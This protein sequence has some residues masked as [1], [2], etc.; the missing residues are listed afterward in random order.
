[1]KKTD[2]LLECLVIYTRL[3]NRPFSADALV[4]DLPVEEGR[5]TPRLFSHESQK[6][7]SAFS[8]AALRGGF[9]SKLVQ[10]KLADI[11]SLLLPV[12]L[13][14]RDDN[15]CILIELSENKKYAKVILPDYEDG[16]ANWIKYED[17][18][19]EYIGYAFL[20]KPI[21]NHENVQKRVL[22][23]EKKHWFWGT[24]KY[25]RTIYSDVLV[26]SF[27]INLFALASPLFTMNVY[28]RVVPN[29]AIDTM[30]VLATGVFVV[31]TFDMLLKFM[32][33][34]F[35]ENAAKKSDIIMSSII[36]EKVLNLK[37]SEK[38]K[39]VGSFASNLKDFDSIRGFFAST[40][41][42][43]MVDLPFTLVFLFVIYIIADWLVYLPIASA[44][45]IVLYSFILERPLRRSVEST[46]E[47]SAYKNSILIETLTAL[48][49]IKSMG[50]TGSFQW[51]WEEATGDIA[52]KSLKSRI[53]TNSITTF[54]NYMVSINTV[55]LVVAGV[56]SINDKSLSMGGLIAVVMMGSRAL[57]PL[58]QVASLVANFQQ[59]K[60]AYN[61]IDDIMNLPTER[62]V[63][64][65]FV[66][67]PLFKGKI[68]FKNVSFVYP[69]TENAVLNNVSFVIEPGESVGIIGTNG[70]GKSTIEKLI[71]GL[72]SPTEGSILIDDIDISQIDPADLR[73]NI[74]YIPQDVVLFQ[75]T[76][77]QNIVSKKPDATDEQ[78]LKAAEISG[79]GNFINTNPL[80]FD[81]NV[82]ERGEFLSG[83]Q[84]QAIGVARA[85]IEVSPILLF[86]EPSNA[87]DSVNENTL[88]HT[89]ENL[90]KNNTL[91]L[92]SH[93]NT[94]LS[95]VDRLI[96]IDNG[97]KALDGTKES[98]IKQLNTPKVKGV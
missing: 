88:I 71:I 93:K 36:Y 15:A 35:L 16:S 33:S 91:I 54:V 48:E 29:N 62:E 68:E 78:I 30:W 98:V 4:A 2:P 65:K 95:L 46:Y 56:Y 64:K 76:L 70:S 60:T 89:M 39:S 75:G 43:A 10:Y 59:T 92:I 34:Y 32:R 67:R 73:R 44:L 49:T 31:Y 79:V 58:G 55:A 77:K 61:A 53:I 45:I 28:D 42:A 3:H 5:T 90:K 37:M 47:A 97:A 14:L 12:I 74:S 7:K 83:G 20:L 18:E 27:L 6:S 24:L 87:M 22:K 40:T 19:A 52:S 69:G 1:M 51:K 26:A 23:H 38:P 8:R 21:E 72:Y 82:G 86:D 84:R 66:T 50:I 25:S 63:G 17:L 13:N 81:M 80:G 41:I 57:A 94:L 96:L 85:L 11:S 9:N